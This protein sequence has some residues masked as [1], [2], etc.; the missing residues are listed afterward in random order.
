MS[1]DWWK[2]TAPGK[3]G[4]FPPILQPTP[5]RVLPFFALVNPNFIVRN[6]NNQIPSGKLTAGQSPFLVA[7]SIAM[8]NYQRVL[9][10]VFPP[11][12]HSR[13]I[14]QF[15]SG[16]EQGAGQLFQPEA[17]NAR[18]GSMDLLSSSNI[19]FKQFQS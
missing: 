11:S 9:V 8:L 14:P 19:Y 10:S 16:E 18:R 2:V 17:Q 5:G 4:V 12:T 3:D 6:Y 15:N 7:K 1:R 13:N